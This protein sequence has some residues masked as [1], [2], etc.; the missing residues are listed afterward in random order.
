MATGKP[1]RRREPPMRRS[2]RSSPLSLASP[3]RRA[4]LSSLGRSGP[5]QAVI[6]GDAQSP[7]RNWRYRDARLRR[8]RGFVKTGEELCG[9]FRQVTGDRQAAIACDRSEA[10]K[11][12]VLL[13]L[14]HAQPHRLSRR[15]MAG[16]LSGRFD[17]PIYWCC[18]PD[19]HR[20]RP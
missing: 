4:K 19:I 9:C 7:L 3:S 11:K 6:D 15:I 14:D 1:A 12:F 2:R 5:A 13:R 16:K 8:T 10:D 17:L 18:C 20:P